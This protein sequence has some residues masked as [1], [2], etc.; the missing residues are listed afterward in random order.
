MV[1]SASA[2]YSFVSIDTPGFYK[3]A[4]NIANQITITVSDVTLDMNGLTIS[5]GASGISINSGLS[6]VTIRNG[7][8]AEVSDGIV[9]NT[10]CT[11]VI[12][13][14]I[15][16]KN[17][18]RGINIDHATD[19]IIRNCDFIANTTGLHSNTAHN[20]VVEDC[21]ATGNIQ[22]S[23]S[24]LT[25]TTC[26]FIDC[27]ALATG[28]G[29]TRAFGDASNIFGFVTQNG[30]GNIFER[31]IANATQGL[32]TTS[33]NSIVA[34]FAFRGI[35]GCS[36]I[37]DCEASNSITSLNGFT[38]PYGIWL[39][40]R[41]DGLT[42]VTA[43]VPGNGTGES[44]S[45]RAIAWSPDGIYVAA[46][47]SIEGSLNNN[48]LFIYQ[49]NRITRDLIQVASI[50]P[51]GGSTNDTIE[52]IQWS[53]DGHYVAIGMSG[54][55]SV[56]VIIYAFDNV[57]N[58]LKQVA[59]VNPNG[60]ADDSV[61]SVDWSSDGIFLAVGGSLSGTTN[62]DVFV[63]KF[64]K[65]LQTLTEVGS[66]NPNGGSAA[67][68]VLS[69]NWS[70]DGIYLAV[71][72]LINGTTDLLVY[73]FNPST[74]FLAQIAALNPGGT[75]PSINVVKW[76]PDEQ[77]LAVGTPTTLFLFTFTKA[78][79]TFTQVM[80][81]SGSVASLRW[82]PDGSYLAAG[83]SS[84]VG[85]DFIVYQLN[86]ENNILTEVA[87]ANPDGGAATDVI[88]SVDWS[89]DG[90]YIALGTINT[91]AGNVVF[92]Y[93]GFSF[94]QNNVITDNMVYCNIVNN[95]GVGISGSS[96]AN[97]IINNTSYNNPFNYSFVTNI[98]NQFFNESPSQ[99]QNIAQIS[100]TAII[101]P[102][103]I[104]TRIKRTNLLLE[105]LIDNLL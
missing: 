42:T 65:V 103:D 94:P 61:F 24:L 30:Y 99:L 62:N 53:P 91:G 57:V 12:L 2:R 48:D 56:S 39:Q 100:N 104:P 22:A 13:K 21:V 20:V 105:S 102:V 10:A 82:S 29:N 75:G 90:G 37:I 76:S 67:D 74:G 60:G 87:S 96:I 45:I 55:I 43:L 64:D 86:R 66:V 3:L 78:T 46:G 32:T 89:P 23:Y 28:E 6:N 88:A 50:N 34:G 59:S 51:A 84:V 93:T 5:N 17:C 15:K 19:I 8:I 16:V 31:C 49:F 52:S 9:V 35:E 95:K 40:S 33:E 69:V 98:F 27:K 63:Y 47:G 92:I 77:Y 26:T 25:S 80:D 58:S 79:E 85:N 14:D 4:D 7:T 68:Q 44:D 72:G 18:I 83:K 71:G 38:V 73:R 101:T 70:P 36:K 54:M 41:F 1:P 97:L 81:I 11:N